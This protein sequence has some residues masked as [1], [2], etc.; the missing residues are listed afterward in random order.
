MPA[1]YMHD[2]V[3]AQYIGER[4]WVN[5]FNTGTIG[6]FFMEWVLSV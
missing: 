1:H 4:T 6:S 2:S 3:L 5:D